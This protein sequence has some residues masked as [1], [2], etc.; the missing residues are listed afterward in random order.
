VYMPANLVHGIRAET[1]VSMLLL[2]L[3]GPESD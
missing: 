2:L 3:K 1:P